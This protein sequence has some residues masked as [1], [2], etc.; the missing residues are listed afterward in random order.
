VRFELR[1]CSLFLLR[2]Y[3]AHRR[4][5]PEAA[6]VRYDTNERLKGGDHVRN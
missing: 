1:Q 3:P 6:I 5:I 4:N 2:V